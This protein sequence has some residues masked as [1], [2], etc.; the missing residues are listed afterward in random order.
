MLA[1]LFAA[2]LAVAR[3]HANQ[4]TMDAKIR[5]DSALSQVS[6][7]LFTR[8]VLRLVLQTPFGYHGAVRA[9]TIITRCP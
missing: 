5:D 9:T 4:V 7:Q 2:A 6:L 3:I 1:F 8:W